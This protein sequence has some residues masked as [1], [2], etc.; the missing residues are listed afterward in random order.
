MSR[1]KAVTG[2]LSDGAFAVWVQ[3]NLGGRG[4]SETL[5]SLV[6]FDAVTVDVHPNFPLFPLCFSSD[7]IE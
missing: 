6:R 1:S 3:V 5:V 7:K 2:Q 4:F